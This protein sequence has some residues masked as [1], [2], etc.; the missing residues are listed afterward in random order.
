MA[1]IDF[2]GV[3]LVYPVRENRGLTLKD[4]IL[5]GLL[6][7][8]R[9]RRWTSVQALN[10]V[11]FRINDGERVGIIG[12]NGAGK[13]TLLR[14]IAGVFP[15]HAGQRRV[16]GGVCSLFDIHLG[17]EYCATGWENIRYRGYLQGETPRSIKA[18][19]KDIAD[20]T[21]LGDFV[22]LPLNCYS[23]GMIMRLAFSIATS[24]DPEILLID[25]IF[26]TGDLVFQKKAEARMRDFM[27]RASIVV[28]VGHN[29]E[30]LQ[31]FC[32][33]VLWLNQGAVMADGAPRDVVALY[34]E[35]TAN[36]RVAA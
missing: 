34:R 26:S 27:G 20:F 14:A 11:S 32:T 10:K 4:L 1:L 30:F 29:L 23:T 15:V 8:D 9:G 19:M 36:P 21:E 35:E 33:R 22:D 16:E 12:R 18:K 31:E 28:M 5:K 6:R 17:F 13:S 7:F 24:G 25:E 2:E 3:D